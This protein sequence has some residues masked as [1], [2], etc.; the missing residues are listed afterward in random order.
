VAVVQ[1]AE[2]RAKFGQADLFEIFALDEPGKAADTIP[3]R[4][5]CALAVTLNI[6]VEQPGF[7]Q[8]GQ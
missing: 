5:D 8:A 4:R 7:D 3:A 2:E 1:V 6:A